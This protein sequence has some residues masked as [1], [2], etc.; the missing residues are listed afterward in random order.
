MGID[1]QLVIQVKWKKIYI[2][3]YKGINPPGLFKEKE[4]KEEFNDTIDVL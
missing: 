4:K 3:I 1:Y 2:N